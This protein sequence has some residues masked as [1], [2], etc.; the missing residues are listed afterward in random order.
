MFF[1]SQFQPGAIVRFTYQA[2]E[3]DPFK[4]VLVLHPGWQGKVHA[5][6]LKRVTP[7]ERE[8]LQAIFD[9]A[10]KGGRHR[11][12]LVNDILRRMD[13]VVLVKN[14]IGFYQ[15][16]VKP[17]LRTAG[18]CYRQYWPQYIVNAQVVE[19]TKVEGKVTNPAAAPLFKKT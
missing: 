7:A 3:E 5:L 11:I 1:A 14:P 6:D 9:P 18:D 16:M 17:F 13:P 19:R 10:S 15:R 12:P 8:V 2:S 4:E